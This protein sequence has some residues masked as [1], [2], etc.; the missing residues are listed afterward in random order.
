M[1]RKSV[2]HA[3]LGLLSE[4]LTWSNNDKIRM[5][6]HQFLSSALTM[7]CLFERADRHLDTGIGRNQSYTDHSHRQEEADM[8]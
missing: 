7:C 2:A 6:V 8:F 5:T 4:P 3:L 1:N